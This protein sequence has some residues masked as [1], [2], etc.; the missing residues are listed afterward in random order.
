MYF[1]YVGHLYKLYL[2][3]MCQLPVSWNNQ[4]TVLQ[5]TH[6]HRSWG[7]R[8]P[9]YTA[10]VMYAARKTKIRFIWIIFFK[11]MFADGIFQKYT[12]TEF[13]KQKLRE[14][15]YLLAYFIASFVV[16]VCNLLVTFNCLPFAFF[17]YLSQFIGLFFPLVH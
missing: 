5:G 14:A 16:C 6:S 13:I 3:P 10:H 17:S 9:L 11:E 12:K 15:C 1:S 2:V 8:N 4:S 7:K